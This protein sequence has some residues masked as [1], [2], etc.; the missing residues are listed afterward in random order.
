MTF[1]IQRWTQIELHNLNQ[2]TA[3]K[4]WPNFTIDFDHQMEEDGPYHRIFSAIPLA[5]KSAD[6]IEFGNS[7]MLID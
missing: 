2:T 7:E 1:A 6:S 4:Y 3:A 5:S